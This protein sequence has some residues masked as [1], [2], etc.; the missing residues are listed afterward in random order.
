MIQNCIS[1]DRTLKAAIKATVELAGR[2]APHLTFPSTSSQLLSAPLCHLILRSWGSAQG[3]VFS[4]FL[5]KEKE[6]VEADKTLRFPFRIE[7]IPPEA[8]CCLHTACSYWPCLKQPHPSP[9]IMSSF[10]S[11]GWLVHHQ[12]RLLC[13]IWRHGPFYWTRT[14]TE[15]QPGSVNP[16]GVRCGPA[17]TWQFN[18]LLCSVPCPSFFATGWIPRALLKKHSTHSHPIWGI[19]M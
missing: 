3:R 11:Q 17:T 16:H 6:G 5:Q 2:P 18:C 8:A 9:N 19:K 13:G 7:F 14:M 10:P 12:D 4:L 15:S 1:A